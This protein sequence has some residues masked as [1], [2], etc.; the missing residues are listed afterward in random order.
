MVEN[1]INANQYMFVK[2]NLVKFNVIFLMG[3][4]VGLVKVAGLGW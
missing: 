4:Q 3:L 1:I 2:T